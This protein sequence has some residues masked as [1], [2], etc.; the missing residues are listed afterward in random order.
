MHQGTYRQKVQGAQHVTAALEEKAQCTR[1]NQKP[2]D[3][4]K[5]HQ[6]HMS[7]PRVRRLNRNCRI[8]APTKLDI[9]ANW[10]NAGIQNQCTLLGQVHI[11][12][13]LEAR[14]HHIQVQKPVAMMQQLVTRL[15]MEK[16]LQELLVRAAQ[17][18]QGALTQWNEDD[19]YLRTAV[20]DHHDCPTG[21][22][23][24]YRSV[25][26]IYAQGHQQLSSRS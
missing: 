19:V 25:C 8:L 20:Q 11:P 13:T 21:H 9:P 23:S 18:L 12:G 5:L 15:N 3:G 10:A 22:N 1:G 2:A 4:L 16:T 14:L 7:A 17:A 26:G 24:T 6:N